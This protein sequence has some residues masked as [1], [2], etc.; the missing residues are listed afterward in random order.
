[1]AYH[2]PNTKD[3]GARPDMAAKA[4]ACGVPPVPRGNHFSKFDNN[5]LMNAF[6]TIMKLQISTVFCYS[7]CPS[8][9]QNHRTDCSHPRRFRYALTNSEMLIEFIRDT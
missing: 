8:R 3:N 7:V 6:N 1:M 9:F 4:A 2:V 5:Y